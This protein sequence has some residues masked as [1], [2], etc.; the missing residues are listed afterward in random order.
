VGVFDSQTQQP[1][2]GI[3][4]TLM[5][6]VIALPDLQLVTDVNGMAQWK[7]GPVCFGYD[8]KLRFLDPNGLY[9]PCFYGASGQDIFDNGIPVDLAAFPSI[10][11]PL[12]RVG[13]ADVVNDILQDVAGM[14]L[15]QSTVAELTGSLAS[16]AK[17]LTDNNPNNDKAACGILTGFI[18]KLDAKVNNGAVSQSQADALTASGEQIRS[19]LGC[20]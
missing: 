14:G 16:A 17:I 6:S 19:M 10:N 12:A 9:K 20:K 15:D 13:P 3:R 5:N 4:I 2:P 1:I 8:E 11:Q 18:H 7:I